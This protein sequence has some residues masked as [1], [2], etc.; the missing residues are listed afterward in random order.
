V[1]KS[2]LDLGP[3]KNA[4]S[5]LEDG[6]RLAEQPGAAE[7]VRD[8]VI[9]RFEYTYE[10]CWKMLRRYLEMTEDDPQRVDQ[11][12]FGDLIRLGFERGLLRS[13]YDVWAGFRQARGTTSHTYDRLKAEQVYSVIPAFYLEARFLFDHLRQAISSQVGK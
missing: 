7:I 2:M 10:L 5:Q 13:S 11:L 4:L 9:Q 8:G 3:L 12:S 1:L 6:L